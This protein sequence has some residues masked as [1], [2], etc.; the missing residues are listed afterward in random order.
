MYTR[1]GPRMGCHFHDTFSKELYRHLY[2]YAR[3]TSLLREFA[4]VA[5]HRSAVCS[6]AQS[7]LIQDAAVD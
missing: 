6:H 3:T 7:L 1:P 5:E 2:V 4:R